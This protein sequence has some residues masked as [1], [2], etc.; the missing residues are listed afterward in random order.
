MK[1]KLM[2]FYNGALLTYGILAVIIAISCLFVAIVCW[3]YDGIVGYITNSDLILAATWLGI[4][5]VI[6]KVYIPNEPEDLE[7]RIYFNQWVEY[8]TFDDLVSSSNGTASNYSG[9]I[10]QTPTSL[11]I[12]YQDKFGI[13][14]STYMRIFTYDR[15]DYVG[16]DDTWVYPFLPMRFIRLGE[17]YIKLNYNQTLLTQA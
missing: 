10:I 2:K 7:N 16:L 9:T 6:I 13:K 15:A 5:L 3:Y 12:S 4:G 11:T 17:K 14:T 8:D 1:K